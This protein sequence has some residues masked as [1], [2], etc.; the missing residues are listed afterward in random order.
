MTTADGVTRGEAVE[1]A[2]RWRP[3]VPAWR[4]LPSRALGA[5]GR[6]LAGVETILGETQSVPRSEAAAWLGAR[7]DATSI[8]PDRASEGGIRLLD[9]MQARGLTFRY[10]ALAGMNAGASFW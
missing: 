3:A 8:P 9:A 7:V 5:L 4:V 2:A 10:V 6:A 1:A